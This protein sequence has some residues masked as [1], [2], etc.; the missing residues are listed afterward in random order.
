ML[1]EQQSIRGM[2]ATRAKLRVARPL[3]ALT[4]HLHITPEMRSEELRWWEQ[5]ALL[6]E[7]Y[8]WV[9]PPR[10][11][12]LARGRYLNKVAEAFAGCRHVVDFGCGNGW[13]ARELASRVGCSITGLDFSEPQIALARAGGTAGGRIDFRVIDSVDA[14]PRADGYLLH[15]VLH[16][17]SITEIADLLS[18]LSMRGSDGARVV[19]VEP[20]RFC[21]H[22]PTTEQRRTLERATALVA[23]VARRRDEAGV[24]ESAE[25]RAI[26]GRLAQRWWGKDP[27]G[28]SPL[29]KPFE[30]GE[31]AELLKQY[32]YVRDHSLVQLLDASQ[33]L[34]GELALLD[35]DAPDLAAR[36]AR[37]LFPAADAV[38]REILAWASRPDL[39]WYMVMATA[40]VTY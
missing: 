34:A 22:E 25:T 11:Q 19:V 39:G 14:L 23:E 15:G 9:L 27:Y 17:L 18:A 38:E 37:E 10:L 16:H 4:R 29:E 35:R 12:P 24:I 33:V 5:Y 7:R 40:D 32:F 28:P 3:P 31:L 21:G 1:E 20:V 30:N 36:L 13:I 2:T 8:A 6:E 26:R